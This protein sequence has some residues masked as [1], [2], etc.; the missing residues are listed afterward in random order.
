MKYLYVDNFRGFKNAYIPIKSVSFL[1]GENSTGK[2]SIISLAK[3]LSSP[4]FWFAQGFD[5]DEVKMGHFQDIVSVHASDKSYFR[6]GM[7]EHTTP[8]DPKSK[9]SI[10]AF[11]MTFIE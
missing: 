6:I 7:A 3:I 8:S 4:K 1:V 5:I 10:M 9:G 2:T 11:V